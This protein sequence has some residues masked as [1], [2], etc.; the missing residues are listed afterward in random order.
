[1]IWNLQGILLRKQRLGRL[2]FGFCFT[3]WLRR[4]PGL[5]LVGVGQLPRMMMDIGGASRDAALLATRPLRH[6]GEVADGGMG[7]IRFANPGMN[8]FYLR[9]CA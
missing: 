2:F 5:G 4:F 9:D 6:E 1:M 7:G 8:L 3:G